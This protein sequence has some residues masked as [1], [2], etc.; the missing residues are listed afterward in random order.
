MRTTIDRAGR[1]VL[2][3][4]MRDALGLAEGGDVDVELIDG[5]VTIA[6]PS[7]P[8]HIEQRDGRAVIVADDELPPLTDQVVADTLDSIRP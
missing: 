2:P 3:K 7:V 8:K 5:I 4:P 6:P 1:V